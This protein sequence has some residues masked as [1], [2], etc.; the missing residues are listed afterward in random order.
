M[1]KNRFMVISF[2]EKIPLLQSKFCMI[3]LLALLWGFVNVE[4]AIFGLYFL[5]YM[6]VKIYISVWQ[7]I[8]LFIMQKRYRIYYIRFLI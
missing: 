1:F 2:T 3:G 6:L 7:A 8:L 4:L 5:F